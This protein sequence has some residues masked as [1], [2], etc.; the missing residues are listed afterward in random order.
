VIHRD[1]KP[2]NVFVVQ[3]GD[4]VRVLDFGTSKFRDS[5]LKTT[6][7][8]RILGTHA[9]MSP[10]RLLAN[11]VD[12]RADIFA[13]GHILYEMLSGMH[14]LS[15]GPG[16][17]DSPPRYELGMRQ[18]YAPPPPLRDRAPDVPDYVAAIVQRALAKER[19]QRQQSMAELAS[20]LDRAR[21]RYLREI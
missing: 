19:A 13:L 21:S 2:E 11:V 6:D 1:L 9:Y 16:P 17:L 20:E 15:E 12:H 14:C 8:F 5:A 10:E 7:R 3:P 18:I 4:S